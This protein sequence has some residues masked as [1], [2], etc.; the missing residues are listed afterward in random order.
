[1]TTGKQTPLYAA[2]VRY[3]GKIVEFGGWLLPVQYSNILE[4]HRAVREKAGLFDVSHMGEVLAEGPDA[5]AFVQKIVT[6]DVSRIKNGQVQYSPMCYENGG[7]VDDLLVYK[8]AEDKYFIVINA[9][10]IDKDWEWMQKN[11]AGFNLRLTNLSEVTAELALQGPQAEA[12]LGKLTD[13]PLATIGYYCFIENVTVAG[14]TVMVSRTGYTGEDG[15]EIYCR[16][17]DAEALWD[18]LLET[19]KPFGL[20]PTGLGC[21]DT[22]RFEACLPLYG[23]ELSPD[24]T[25]LEAGLGKFI[26]WDKSDFN[27]KAALAAQKASGLKR[28]LIG[29]EMTGRG[30]AR[31][32]YPVT[33][34]GKVIGFVTTG[35]PAPTA[36]KNMGMA[37]V[38][39]AYAEVGKEL[40]IEIREKPVAAKMVARPFVKHNVKR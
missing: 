20:L 33:A 24:I 30:I 6:N 4:E 35:S 40:D 22:L 2:H 1:M 37:L 17:E 10:N 34:G 18:V 28:K 27:G 26:G 32:E 11:A 16:P 25:P 38:E 9:G 5:L 14:K 36:G 13:A 8:Q 29:F 3:G 12:I 39:A 15:F 21:R 31:A 23:H 19:G 7:V